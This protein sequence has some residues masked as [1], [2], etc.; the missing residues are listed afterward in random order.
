[1][2]LHPRS[3]LTTAICTWLAACAATPYDLDLPRHESRALPAASASSLGRLFAPP[4]DAETSLFAPLDRPD[5]GLDARLALCATAESS[6]DAQ[7]YLWHGDSAGA[8]LLEHLLEAAD[9]GVRV[10][11]LVDGF[12]LEGHEDL[13]ARLDLHPSF[14]IRAFNPALHRSGLWRA[15]E[16]LEHLE[17]FDHRMHNKLFLVDGV[18]AIFGGRNVGDEYFGL[19]ME[20]NFRDFDLLGAGPVVGELQG[21]FDSFWNSEWTVALSEL[22][23]ADAPGAAAA[24]ARA[25]EVVRAEF[26]GDARFAQR[27]G[28]DHAEWIAALERLRAG[29]HPGRA[30]VLHD[31]ADIAERDAASV[32]GKAWERVLTQSG[33]DV[34]IA[35]AYLVPDA[36]LLDDIRTHT[37]AGGRVRILTNSYESTNQP[38]AHAGYQASRRDLLDA[39][40]ELYELR[41]DAWDHVVHR[42]P[43][44]RATRFGLHAKSAVFGDHLVLVG[45]MNLD[46]RSM[47]LN[48]ELGVL[49]ESREL[50][51]Q[52]RRQLERELAARNAWRV[53]EGPDGRL[54]WT[55]AGR[56]RCSEPIP[57][58]LERLA[59]WLRSLLPLRDEV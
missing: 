1:M 54:C 59:Q 4:S 56:H 20:R 53:T 39:G 31:L 6:I 26:V 29:M 14:E 23:H 51:A 18:A 10:R 44:S 9:R 7:S 57:T 15:V 43:G 30:H 46:P 5:E 50:A 40:A 32:M 27:V 28:Y 52:V 11:L 48:T 47:K 58:A 16:V 19:G 55:T 35:T 22:A 17:H 36:E 34:L 8:L 37:S 25:R 42:S 33:G 12:R 24:H 38:L 21:T 3:F 45:S 41:A 2:H 49:V 13:D